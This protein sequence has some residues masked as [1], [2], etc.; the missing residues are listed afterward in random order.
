MKQRVFIF[1]PETCFG[2]NGCVAACVNANSPGEEIHWRNLHKLPPNDG[3]HKTI[4]LS[5]S[6]NHCE[7]PPCAAA[8]PA[9]ALEK[10]ESDGV[11]VHHPE[12]CIGC[13]YCQM[14]CP[15]DAI[16]YNPAKGIV[17]KCHFCFERLEEEREPAC[18]ETC[19]AGALRQLVVETTED[20]SLQREM[21]GLLHDPA[22]GPAIRFQPHEKEKRQSLFPFPPRRGA[23]AGLLKQEEKDG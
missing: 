22:V 2:C 21:P 10:R 8:C 11:V 17:S 23:L 9:N 20:L 4:Y 18:V 6:C 7:N 13:K 15:Y 16:K 12:R 5:I 19:F 1:D 3:D 14:A